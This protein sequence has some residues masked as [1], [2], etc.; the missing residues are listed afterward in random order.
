MTFVEMNGYDREELYDEVR[1]TLH[2]RGYT[3]EE[4]D[5]GV[6]YEGDGVVVEEV[7]EGIEINGPSESEEELIANLLTP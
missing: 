6:L 3:V 2:R 4:G 7:E 5:D 1:Q